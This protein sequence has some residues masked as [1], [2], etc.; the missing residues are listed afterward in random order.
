[1]SIRFLFGFD[2]TTQKNGSPGCATINDL[3]W[4][5]GKISTMVNPLS[6][7]SLSF[8][9]SRGFLFHLRRQQSQF[10]PKFIDLAQFKRCHANPLPFLRDP[11]Q[12]RKDQ[13][14]T[15]LLVKEASNDLGPS[16]LLLKGPLQKV[17][18]PNRL[19]MFH[20]TPQM[21]QTS[22]HIFREGLH[23][24][25]RI[26]G[27][28]LLQHLPALLGCLKVRRFKNATKVNFHLW[29]GLRG[30]LGH[31][32]T[33]FMHQTPL[34]QTLGPHLAD[35][36]NQS[37]SPIGDDHQR[38]PE[39][40]PH[41]ISQQP[42][43]ILIRLLVSQHQMKQDPMPLPGDPPSHQNSFLIPFIESHQLIDCI[44][45]EVNNIKPAQIPL[46]KSLILLP[47]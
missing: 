20:R 16:L 47:V 23:G 25:C 14:Q 18:R 21:I 5:K 41:H 37:R 42:P 11:D 27:L 32:V 13:L 26:K 34:P 4:M 30:K 33:D 24:R 28:I 39:P 36:T 38:N 44:Q 7:L 31:Y 35:G 17:R 40:S 15:T 19:P 1:M 45:K 9:R 10:P 29:D 12:G 6:S 2:E 46:T 22:L 3:H 43:P 8:S